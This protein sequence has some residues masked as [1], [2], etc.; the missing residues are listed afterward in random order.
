MDDVND[1][2]VVMLNLPGELVYL[3][4]LGTCVRTV[5]DEVTGLLQRDTVAY[6]IELAVYEV[7][8]NI[9]EHAY[10]ESSARIRATVTLAKEFNRIIIDLFDSGSSFSIADV[11][12][13]DLTQPQVRGYGLFL[14]HELMDE[15]TYQSDAGTNQWR[16]VKNLAV[17]A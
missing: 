17:D 12:K 10:I 15:V 8:T 4:I 9:V 1:D 2:V 5:L 11:P 3:P 6:H 7:C 14:V 16:L 13:L